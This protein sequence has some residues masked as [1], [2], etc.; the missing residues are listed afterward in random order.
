MR[1]FACNKKLDRSP[2]IVDTR[3]GQFVWVGPDCFKMIR[4]A[5]EA[6]YQPPIRGSENVLNGPRLYTVRNEVTQHE[7]S[8]IMAGRLPEL[9]HK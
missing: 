5:G 4:K 3:D 1:C 6:G 2:T 7:L 8:E 9:S